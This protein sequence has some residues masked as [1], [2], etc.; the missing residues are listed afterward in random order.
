MTRLM[1]CLIALFLSQPA[2]STENN[3]AEQSLELSQVQAAYQSGRQLSRRGTQLGRVGGYTM[4]GGAAFFA[5]GMHSSTSKQ[6]NATENLGV[7]TILAG[8]LTVL[9][10]APIAAAG[11]TRSRRALVRGGL[12][13]PGCGLCVASWVLSIPHPLAFISTP[14]SYGASSIQR[15]LDSE[16]YNKAYATP[17]MSFRFT[18]VFTRRQTGVAVAAQF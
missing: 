18:P 8:A 9:T 6:F 14:L 4:L 15:D 12:A 3:D 13:S 10:G 7:L 17:K 11:T 16:I 1:P 2:W 5:V